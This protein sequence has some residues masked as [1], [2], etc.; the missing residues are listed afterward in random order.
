M[1]AR[2]RWPG[3]VR[4]SS[5]PGCRWRSPPS[6]LSPQTAPFT[7]PATLTAPTT[8]RLSRPPFSRFTVAPPPLLLTGSTRRGTG[9]GSARL[10][11]RRSPLLPTM[12]SLHPWRLLHRPLWLQRR[13]P[14][15]RRRRWLCPN[16]L[17][18]LVPAGPQQPLQTPSPPRPPRGIPT[19]PRCHRLGGSL[20]RRGP[21]G[22]GGCRRPLTRSALFAARAQMALQGGWVRGWMGVVKM[23]AL[24]SPLSG[25]DP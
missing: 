25:L 13:P 5:W 4:P 10:W 12:A 21:Y 18:L 6:L 11:S 20:R 16:P 19:S 15:Q 8:C 17:L 9:L 1:R 23:G 3:P 24:S 7:N 14:A 2:R 22:W